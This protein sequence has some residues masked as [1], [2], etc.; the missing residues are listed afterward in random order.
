MDAK[1]KRK[2]N[3]VFI[4]ILLVLLVVISV[5]PLLWCLASSLRSDVE[6]FAYVF[7]LQWHTFIPVEFTLDSYV[8][9]FTERQFWRPILNTLFVSF[10]AM[11]LGCLVNSIAAF[12][13]TFFDFKG[14]KLCFGIVM[15]SFMVPFE[16]LAIPLYQTIEKLKWVETYKG[17]IVPCI[18]DGFVIFLFIQ[19]FKNIS[20]GFFE[21]ARIDGASWL[22]IYARIAMP[23]AKP[24]LVTAMLLTF[25]NQWSSFLW[26]LLVAHSTELKTVQVAL[27]DFSGQY[28]TFWSQLYAAS[29]IVAV[30]PLIVFLPLQKYYMEAMASSGIKG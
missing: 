28:A 11:L 21:A 6:I 18:A 26:P 22:G 7:P 20:S 27:S 14:K 15:F 12:G 9:V 17:L 3:K 16:V 2:V 29:L 1:L 25:L 13:I 23:I 30:I 8:A 24:V 5:F 10:S 19:F 4:I